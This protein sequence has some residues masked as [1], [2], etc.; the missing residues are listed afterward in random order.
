MVIGKKQKQAP[1]KKKTKKTKKTKNKNQIF[2]IVKYITLEK[3]GF[4]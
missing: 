1:R 4:Q 2:C 3:C